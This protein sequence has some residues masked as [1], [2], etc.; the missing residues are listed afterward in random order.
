[1]TFEFY[2]ENNSLLV[3]D[4][5]DKSN[6]LDN[7]D[8]DRLKE[9]GTELYKRMIEFFESLSDDKKEKFEHRV[10]PYPSSE[11]SLS[12]WNKIFLENVGLKSKGYKLKSPKKRNDVYYWSKVY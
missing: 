11:M 1:M 10:I 5:I 7:E 4:S 8:K 3:T 2:Q 6:N 12:T 9:I